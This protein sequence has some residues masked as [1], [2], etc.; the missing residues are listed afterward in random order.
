MLLIF[1][2]LTLMLIGVWVDELIHKV[3]PYDWERDGL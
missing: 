2:L 1:G 3:R